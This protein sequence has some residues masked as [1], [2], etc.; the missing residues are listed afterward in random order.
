MSS[1]QRGIRL[2]RTALKRRR[3][4]RSRP[5]TYSWSRMIQGSR[6]IL[7]RK[8]PTLKLHDTCSF[9]LQ[10]RAIARLTTTSRRL[11]C[12]HWN[13]ILSAVSSAAN[14]HYAVV[15]RYAGDHAF[16]FV[17][18]LD[19]MRFPLR[20]KGHP[21]PLSCVRLSK[22]SAELYDTRKSPCAPV[23]VTRDV[24]KSCAPRYI[25]GFETSN[26]SLGTPPSE[27]ALRPRAL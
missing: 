3:R 7:Y 22:F 13:C 6:F 18:A 14:Y 12:Q 26:L 2:D 23:R 8:M 11:S 15:S 19:Q 21:V 10:D 16:G 9:V 1:R 4:H 17:N 25:P 20:R 5:A 27:R 24:H